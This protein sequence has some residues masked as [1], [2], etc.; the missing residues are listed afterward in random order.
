[1]KTAQRFI[2]IE[3]EQSI[4]G[5]LLV[6]NTAWDRVAD[7]LKAEDFSRREHRAI[8]EALGRLINTMKPA[9]VVTVLEE[10]RRTGEEEDGSLGY[11]NE[12][13]SS[14]PSSRNV[15]RYGE[16][17]RERSILRGMVAKADQVH[18]IAAGEQTL[19]EKTDAIAA[20]FSG[21][22]AMNSRK[23]PQSMSDVMVKVI[24]GINEVAEGRG[25]VWSTGIQDL[26]RMTGG[27]LRPGD[28]MYLAARPSV[29]KTSLSLQI[30]KAIAELYSVPALVLSQEMLAE[31]L[32]RRSLSSAARVSLGHIKT[33][34]LSDDE[35]GRLAEG[36]DKLGRL[37]MWIDDEAAL[38]PA[39]I[40]A[41][42]RSV[43]G[44]KLIVLDYLQLSEG[45][46]DTRS[47]QVGSVSRALK[48]LAKELGA[49]VIALSQLNR[50]VDARPGRRPQMSDLRDSGEI[51]QDAD[52]IA[53]LWHLG[54]DD[55]AQIKP[56]GLDIAKNRDGERGATVLN[57]HGATQTWTQSTQTLDDFQHGKKQHQGGFE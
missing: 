53:F 25:V 49:A 1:M 33:A 41:K 26:D 38:K 46:G 27:G 8:F 6:D 32:G 51:E 36:V 39:A 34:K 52:V 18:E 54:S 35:W 9:D 7:L 23:G 14:V 21:V 40:R 28:L 45:D 3:A 44:V 37:P 5:S 57:L 13:A 55:A 15:R 56:I 43:K 17:V 16:I 22:D 2:S 11:L 20:L 10:L 31:A 48:A 12:L 4:L 29:G 50:A 42:A 30:T 19:S 24:D 47:Q